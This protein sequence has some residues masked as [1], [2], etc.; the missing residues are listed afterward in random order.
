MKQL[1]LDALRERKI[2][3]SVFIVA[4]VFWL[5]DTIFE[6]IKGFGFSLGIY[7]FALIVL[8]G[9][10][11]LK[12]DKIRNATQILVSLFLVNSFILFFYL[13]EYGIYGYEIAYIISVLLEIAV[14]ILI[15]LFLFK[16]PKNGFF[17]LLI[18]IC[19]CTLFIL[20]YDI[21]FV[22]KY[23]QFQLLLSTVVCICFYI[24]SCLIVSKHL[25]YVTSIQHKPSLIEQELQVL[26]DKKEVGLLSEEE[27]T[28]KR[29]EIMERLIK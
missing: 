29:N 1:L 3:T 19:I 2:E 21:I 4:V 27:Y 12:L 9:W 15:V 25:R 20:I 28:R 13:I 22:V 10:F 5:L 8:F 23:K 17:F 14:N 26:N 6:I 24:E 7:F 18:S 16:K 11:F